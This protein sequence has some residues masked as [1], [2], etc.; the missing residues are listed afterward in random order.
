MHYLGLV[1]VKEPTDEA[2]NKEMESYEGKHWDWYRC[3]GRWDGWLHGEEEEKRR[4]THNGFNFDDSNNCAERNAV[5]VADLK[6]R[7]IPHFFV[8]DTYFIPQT[9]WNDFERSDSKY[10]L[11]D[12]GRFVETPHFQE[13]WEKALKDHADDWVVVVDAHN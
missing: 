13:R 9:Y 8:V 2:V 6:L 4:E 11:G 1:F 12:Y 7:Y 3:G 5:R 10:R